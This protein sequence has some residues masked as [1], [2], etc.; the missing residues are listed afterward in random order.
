MTTRNIL[1]G[2]LIV[3]FSVFFG[4]VVYYFYSDPNKIKTIEK[5]SENLAAV[6]VDDVAI[7]KQ[8]QFEVQQKIIW[9]YAGRGLASSPYSYDDNGCRSMDE[10]L[11]E[12]LQNGWKIVSFQEMNERKAGIYTTC[13]GRD[14]LIEKD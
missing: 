8:N 3:V 14:V 9:S 1:I 7:E 13:F 4:T 5:N 11:N 12:F 10:N 6:P 2:L